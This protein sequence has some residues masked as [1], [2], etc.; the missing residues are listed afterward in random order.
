MYHRVANVACDPWGLCVA[1]EYFAEH[2][3]VLRKHATVL[4][5]QDLSRMLGEGTLPRRAVAVTFDDGYADNLDQA[6]PLLEHYGIPA[7]F[8]LTV[9]Y[10]GS[11]QEYWWDALEQVISANDRSTW[12]QRYYAVWEQLY[13]LPEIDK[14]KSLEALYERLGLERV[15]RPTHRILSKEEALNLA[16]GKL[17]EIGA[18]TM[19]HPVLGLMPETVQ[20][21]EI[22]GSKTYLEELLDR[23][24]QSFSY[25][26]GHY[27][28]ATV[29]L[30][31]EAG[32]RCA[33]TTAQTVLHP[34]TNGF[35]LPRVQVPS[36]DGD[37]FARQLQAWMKVCQG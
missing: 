12:E 10:L 28:P 24:V 13:P 22:F 14:R 27:T 2:M 3:E 20:R 37:A 5:L 35:E 9:G 32:F 6:K 25:P 33:C 21:E 34:S 1:P 23:P 4:C 11:Q 16:A 18:H 8:F 36:V 17:I 19:M 7:T 30:V 31:R 29:S 15:V 26:H